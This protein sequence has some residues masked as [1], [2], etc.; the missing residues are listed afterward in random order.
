M[1]GLWQFR[2]FVQEAKDAGGFWLDEVD[3]VLIV[4]KRYLLDTEALFLVQVLLVLEYPLVEELLQLLVAVVD[5]ELL[6]R[7]DGEV[8]EASNVQHPD[9]VSRLLEGDGL[10]DPAD[11]VVKQAGVDGFG[12]GVTG[13]RGLV[14]LQRDHDHRAFETTFGSL[15]NE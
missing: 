7:V 11:D 12:K 8:L 14:H 13:I 6:E 5:A 4:D 1:A 9:V 3:A 2:L 10:V 15:G